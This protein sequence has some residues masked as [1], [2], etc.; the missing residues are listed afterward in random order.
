LDA[1]VN[2][3]FK[4]RYKKELPTPI[5]IR[6]FNADQTKNMRDLDPEGAL[7]DIPRLLNFIFRY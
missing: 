6:P 4:D 1:A 7:M 5:E 3:I 2:V